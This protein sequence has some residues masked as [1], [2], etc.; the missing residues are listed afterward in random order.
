M[1]LE[2]GWKV[3]PCGGGQIRVQLH[4]SDGVVVSLNSDLSK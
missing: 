4:N 2:D 1:M 3:T